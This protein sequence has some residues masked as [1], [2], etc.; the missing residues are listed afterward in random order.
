MKQIEKNDLFQTAQ[1]SILLIYT[2]FS[3]L[4]IGE[5]FL[6]GWEPWPLVPIVIGNGV[7]WMLHIQQRMTDEHRIQVITVFIMFTFFFYGS[8]ETST[9]DTVAVMSVV[10][11]LYTMFCIK[12]LITILQLLYY[13]TLAYI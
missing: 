7:A 10:M 13:L 8:H 12:P 2:I 5:S 11:I 9:F 4:L 6:M 1:L 3:G